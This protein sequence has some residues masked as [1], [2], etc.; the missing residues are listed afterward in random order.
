[1]NIL[2]QLLKVGAK[3]DAVSEAGN[4][5]PLHIAVRNKYRD[6]VKI[7][8][9]KGASTTLYNS[10]DFSPLQHS[11]YIGNLELVQDFVA[12]DK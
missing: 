2:Q 11:L 9:D 6:I 10:L 8:L 7:L 12:H 1:L 3:I 5:T 4:Q